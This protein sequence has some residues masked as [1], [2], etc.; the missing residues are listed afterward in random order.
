MIDPT[1]L[2]AHVLRRIAADAS[3]DAGH[4]NQLAVECRRA[5]YMEAARL[6]EHNAE[7]FRL[8]ARV[9]NEELR[10]RGEALT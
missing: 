4:A 1:R 2:K 10:R 8:V 6:H 3:W 5:S 7:G 9:A